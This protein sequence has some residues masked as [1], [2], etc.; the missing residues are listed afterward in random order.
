MKHVYTAYTKV[1][2][3]VTFFFVK[4]YSVFP[5]CTDCP[6]VLDSMGMHIDFYR[7]CKIAEL[8][9]SEIIN[10]LL[11]DMHIMPDTAKVIPMSGFKSIT[12][13]LIKNTQHAIL[14]FRIAGFN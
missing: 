14:K 12:H 13:S 6:R 11:N 7:A 2:N 1:V 5:E 4:K 9:D 10:Q 3:N 8:E